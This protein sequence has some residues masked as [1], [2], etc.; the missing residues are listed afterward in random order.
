MYHL[1][2]HAFFKA[3]LFLGAGSVIH[4]MHHEQDIWNMGGLETEIAGDVLDVSDRHAGVDGRPAVERF[5]QQRRNSGDGVRSIA[6]GLFPIS[7]I[8]A[9][10]TTFYMFA[11]G[12]GRL[13]RQGA[14]RSLRITRTNRRW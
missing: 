2:T 8:V 12:V 7:V 9:V 1:T 14:F 10:L 4:A 6:V 11:V 3:L 5:L 13:L